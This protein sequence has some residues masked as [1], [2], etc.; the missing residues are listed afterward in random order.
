MWSIVRR[1]HTQKG[2]IFQTTF[3]IDTA[4]TSRRRETSFEL[5]GIAALQ[6]SDD[7]DEQLPPRHSNKWRFVQSPEED[8]YSSQ[9]NPTSEKNAKRNKR[10]LNGPSVAKNRRQVVNIEEHSDE[11]GE[12][13]I[14]QTPS[15]TKKKK[16]KRSKSPSPNPPAQPSTSDNEE[17]QSEDA[18]AKSKKKKENH[19]KNKE[20]TKDALASFIA[21]QDRVNRELAK[22]NRK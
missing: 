6:N 17:P 4:A 3:H 19:K 5:S 7:D 9:S 10:P 8:D 16:S 22:G 13:F 2:P 20:K 15:L 12:M 18:E 1:L 21:D 14:T 11:E